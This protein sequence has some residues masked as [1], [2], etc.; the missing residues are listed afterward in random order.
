MRGLENYSEALKYS[1]LN[2][3]MSESLKDTIS[4]FLPGEGSW[5]YAELGDRNKSFE[6]ASLLVE[7]LNSHAIKNQSNGERFSEMAY[8]FSWKSV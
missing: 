7:L 8:R 4:I 2:L 3:K 6:Y 5:T 1:L